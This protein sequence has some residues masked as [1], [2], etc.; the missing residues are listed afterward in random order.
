V[1]GAVLA[2]IA[3]FF[4]GIITGAFGAVLAGTGF[5]G[6]VL[7]TA[8]LAGALTATG[9]TTLAGGGVIVKTISGTGSGV[10]AVNQSATFLKN[11]LNIK[12]LR[13]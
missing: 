4:L 7:V 13:V 9:G 5:A 1:R 6:V 2:T 11:F 12:I 3:G 10:G 8:G